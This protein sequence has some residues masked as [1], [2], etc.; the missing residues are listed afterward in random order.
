MGTRWLTTIV[1][2]YYTGY[3]KFFDTTTNE[4]DTV[5]W[6]FWLNIWTRQFLTQA[7][8]QTMNDLVDLINTKISEATQR[9][10]SNVVFVNN[11]DYYG[12]TAGRYCQ[13]GVDENVN[14]N[15]AGLLFYQMKTTDTPW[16]LPAWDPD[17]PDLSDK[18]SISDDEVLALESFKI[19]AAEY[20]HTEIEVLVARQD[21][22]SPAD[23]S[24][25]INEAVMRT[26]QENPDA[27]LDPNMIPAD[28]VPYLQSE[29][30]DVAVA[31]RSL[32]SS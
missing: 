23:P 14:A 10:G 27:Q 11:D 19:R 20:N 32:V 9:Q 16:G 4:C 18:R 22:V 31:R 7:R 25:E 26:I 2:S 5:S 3:A 13:P 1:F 8:R 12:Q 15:R 28:I 30:V 6:H 21:E 17:D 24:E 29:G